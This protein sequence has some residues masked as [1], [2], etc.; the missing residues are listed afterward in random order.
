MNKFILI[1]IVFGIIVIVVATVMGEVSCIS[2]DAAITKAITFALPGGL[3]QMEVPGHG[4]VDVVI[5]VEQIE[6]GGY[7]VHLCD[8][9][10][11]CPCRPHE[12]TWVGMSCDGG[13]TFLVRES[14][15]PLE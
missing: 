3:R 11:L 9:N 13:R 15:C 10:R 5:D 14:L 7:I 8:L 6:N 2:E 12:G 1:G 4:M